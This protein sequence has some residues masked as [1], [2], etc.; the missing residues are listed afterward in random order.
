[1]SN[2][3]NWFL[4]WVRESRGKESFLTVANSVAN[5]IKD[6]RE[7]YMGLLPTYCMIFTLDFPQRD[8]L[9]SQDTGDKSSPGHVT[10]TICKPDTTA[11]FKGHWQEDV[12]L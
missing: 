3:P 10:A 12:V 11:A 9:V 6:K 1:M 5:F 7:H 4:S 8:T 2:P